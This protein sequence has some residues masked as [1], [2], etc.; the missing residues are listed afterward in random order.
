[1][2]AGDG[3][4]ILRAPADGILESTNHI[5]Q[6]LEEGAAIAAV[7]DLVITAPF[8]GI[9]RGLLRAGTSAVKGMKIGD[10][11]ARGDQRV[12]ELVSDKSLAVGGGVLEVLLTKPEV[13]SKLWA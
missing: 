2:P 7:G 12:C 11:D 4:R 6:R 1:M 13:R 5:G 8:A 10:I 9:L 3:R